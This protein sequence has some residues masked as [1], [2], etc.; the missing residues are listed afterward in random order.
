MAGWDTCIVL[1]EQRVVLGRLARR[2]VR[3]D[4]DS[5][6][7]EAMTEGPQTFRPSIGVSDLVE[8]MR[9]RDL[10]TSLITTPDGRLVGLVLRSEAEARLE[11]QRV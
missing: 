9:K 7:E 10:K 11:Q 6:V 3:S 2:A 4:D 5:S 1:N 8:R